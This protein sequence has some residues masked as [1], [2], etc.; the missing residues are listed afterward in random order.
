VVDLGEGA[1]GDRPPVREKV[2]GFSQQKRTKNEFILPRIDL[3]NWFLLTTAPP[4]PK[5]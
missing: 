5:S 2:F 1:G 3:K 4:L